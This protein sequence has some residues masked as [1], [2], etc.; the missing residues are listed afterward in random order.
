MEDIDP[1]E[2]DEDDLAVSKPEL[3]ELG[4][5]DDPNDEL[6]LLT[7]WLPALGLDWEG[8]RTTG[9]LGLKVEEGTKSGGG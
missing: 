3:A 7:K 1:E 6:D 4:D 8:F 9:L 2:V 5:P